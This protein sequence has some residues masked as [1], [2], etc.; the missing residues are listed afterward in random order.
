MGRTIGASASCENI[1]WSHLRS[2]LTT[3]WP[4]RYGGGT[5]ARVQTFI[6]R[7]A[8][9]GYE[10]C[11]LVRSDLGG[12]G[13]GGSRRGAAA[14]PRA[15]AALRGSGRD[16]R[17]KRLPTV[18]GGAAG[19]RSHTVGA[20]AAQPPLPPPLP[21]P[22]PHTLPRP[23]F[24]RRCGCRPAARSSPTPPTVPRPSRWR[25]RTPPPGGDGGSRGGSRQ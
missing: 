15:T 10:A 6:G 23:A 5:T 1:L 13:R 14:A 24:S 12:G 18:A 22:P 9:D 11:Q 21:P 19:P 2:V 8:R 7:V 17:V 4:I 25:R 20:A 16:G 3:S